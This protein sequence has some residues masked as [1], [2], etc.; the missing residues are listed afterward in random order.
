MN[1]S[2]FRF[3]LPENEPVHDYAPGSA[4]RAA[5]KQELERMAAAPIEIPLIIGG[6]EIRT[7]KTVDV[8]MPTD[9]GHVLARAHMAGEAEVK[10]AIE[11]ALAAKEEWS[12][13]SWVERASV[14]LKAAEL[15]S[16]RY[17]SRINAATMLGQ[18]KSAYQAEIDAACEV[19]DFLR[20]NVYYASQI[21]GEQ[22]QSPARPPQP[23]RV[24]AARGLR[25]HGEPV[26]LHGDR[27]EPEYGRRR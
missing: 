1:N 24:P 8:V 20:Y 15:L 6:K 23:A 14:M 9:H 10:L 17:R 22:P 16:K 18:A 26:Q 27:V 12:T 13:L 5:L 21:Y 25:L 2:V 3:A 7:G 19:I 11:A 4:S